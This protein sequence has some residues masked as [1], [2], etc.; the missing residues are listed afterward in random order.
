LLARR[1]DDLIEPNGSGDRVLRDLDG[2]GVVEFEP[3]L[4][5]RPVPRGADPKSAAE[6]PLG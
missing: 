3:D 5:D 4:G 2:I 6:P 1:E